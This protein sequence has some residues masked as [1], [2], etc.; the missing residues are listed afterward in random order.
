MV[1]D[2]TSSGV[3]RV[4]RWV[5][6]CY[7]VAGTDGGRPLLVDVGLPSQVAQLTAR[8]DPGA[9]PVV[10]ATHLHSDHVGG[11]PALCRARHVDFVVGSKVRHY[12]DGERP[13]TPGPREVARIG[14]VLRDQPI[15]AGAYLDLLRARPSVGYGVGRFALPTPVSTWLDDGDEVPGAPGWFA[16]RAPGH[17]D[18]SIALHHRERRILAS[19]DAVLSVGGRAWFNPELVDRSAGGL[20]VVRETVERLRALRVSVLLPGHGRP[21]VADDVWRDA[22]GFDERPPRRRRGFRCPGL[23]SRSG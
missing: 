20:A 21:V 13:R 15:D 8:L 4:S 22:L 23:R 19:G 1:I 14:P 16:V 18:D 12:A 3:T 11:V 6:N 17:T 10:A 7:V 9:P 2:E 5:F